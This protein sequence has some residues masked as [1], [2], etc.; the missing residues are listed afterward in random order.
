MNAIANKSYVI[1]MAGKNEKFPT[2]EDAKM[3]VSSGKMP[4][5]GVITRPGSALLNKTGSWKSFKPIWDAGKCTHCLICA[6]YCPDDCIPVKDGKRS[7]TNLD[8]CKGCGI[9]AKECPVKAIVMKED[10]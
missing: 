10:K 4:I 5:G 8:F 2:E 9:C 7:D 6:V 1:N 3:K